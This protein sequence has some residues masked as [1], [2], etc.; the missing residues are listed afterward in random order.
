MVKQIRSQ[1]EN[2]ILVD[3][4]DMFALNK[5]IPE[6]NAQTVFTAME[7]MGYDAINVA[8]RDLALG[9]DFFD[10][11]SSG[12]TMACISA[13]LLDARTLKQIYPPY[14]ILPVGRIKVGIIGIT[15]G[16]YFKK[17]DIGQENLLAAPVVDQLRKVLPE[18]RQKAD[19]VILLSHMGE[20]GTSNLLNEKALAGIDVAIVGHN[21]RLSEEPMLMNG[22]L[23]VRNGTKG[24]Y[25]GKL[26]LVFDEQKKIVGHEGSLIRLSHDIPDEPW[27]AALVE[28]FKEKE[29]KL[30][31]DQRDEEKERQRQEELKAKIQERLELLKMPPEEAIKNLP[32]PTRKLY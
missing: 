23:V 19:V 26:M 3:A 9:R 25:L 13:T 32:V 20:K 2:V 17:E 5:P 18:V 29:R 7:K 12:A 14:A 11:L 8:D 4:G 10:S 30:R 16:A 24:G 1:S 28:D 27:A 22:T 31:R 15:K 6:L 21:S